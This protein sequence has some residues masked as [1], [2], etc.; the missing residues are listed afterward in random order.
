MNCEDRGKVQLGDGWWVRSDIESERRRVFR[1]DWCGP[2]EKNIQSIF[3]LY[4][5]E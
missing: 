4:L 3:M 1:R 2:G 5:I